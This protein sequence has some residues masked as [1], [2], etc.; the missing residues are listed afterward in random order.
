VNEILV[1]QR[2]EFYNHAADLDRLQ[3][4][5]GIEGSSPPYVDTDIQQARLA[6]VRREFARDCPP[7]LPSADDAKLILQR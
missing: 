4:R 1:V 2:R 6:D 5:V 7:R 3:N